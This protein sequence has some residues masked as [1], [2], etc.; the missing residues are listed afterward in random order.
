MANAEEH[1]LSTFGSLLRRHRRARGLSCRDLAQL[2]GVALG[3]I[4]HLE[5]GLHC[6]TRATLARLLEALALD[7]ASTAAIWALWAAANRP[8]P[9]MELPDPKVIMTQINEVATLRFRAWQRGDAL[10]ASVLAEELDVL[11]QVYR[12][13]AG[14]RR[15]NYVIQREG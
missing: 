14:R 4:S 9:P 7:E 5:N 3:T 12:V 15:M 13:A 8:G 1:A 2:A 11:W 10:T 6:P